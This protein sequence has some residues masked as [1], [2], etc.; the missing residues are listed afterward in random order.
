MDNTMDSGNLLLLALSSS[1][2]S[3]ATDG[4]SIS[5]NVANPLMV[6]SK[7]MEIGEVGTAIDPS[8]TPS[9]VV[10]V[11]IVEKETGVPPLVL[12]E[13]T[14]GGVTGVGAIDPLLP[15]EVVAGV[16]RERII[17]ESITPTSDLD[18]PRRRKTIGMASA[19]HASIK[20]I[21]LCWV[22]LIKKKLP[23]LV[24]LKNKVTPPIL[25]DSCRRRAASAAFQGVNIQDFMEMFNQERENDKSAEDF[26]TLLGTTVKLQR[27][28]V[29]IEGL[30]LLE[31]KYCQSI[32]ILCLGAHM[33]MQW[34]R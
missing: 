1:Y 31:K 17:S 10:A 19:A 24:P 11:D 29:P 34:G 32:W 13:V 12:E 3:A 16:V 22:R 2:A 15:P 21:D 20:S 7:T 26:Y 14:N 4:I 23:L 30:P 18:P 27:F 33:V 5:G 25:S 6:H 8:L 9:S 28:D